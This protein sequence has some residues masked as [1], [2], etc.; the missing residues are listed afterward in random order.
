M[1]ASF[2]VTPEVMWLQKSG[3]S[4]INK[5]IGKEFGIVPDSLLFLPRVQG[6]FL[7]TGLVLCAGG[8]GGRDEAFVSSSCHLRPLLP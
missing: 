7:R 2:D 3:R 8:R 1:G 5:S 4:H 6:S